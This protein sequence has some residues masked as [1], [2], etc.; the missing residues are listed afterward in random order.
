MSGDEISHKVNRALVWVGAAQT[1]VSLLDMVSVLLILRLWMSVTEYGLAMIAYTL[2]PALDIIGDLGVTSAIVQRDER[3]QERLS[4]LFWFNLLVA[5]G[6]FLILCG[7]GPLLA[8]IHG[9]AV[10]AWMLIVY[11]GKLMFQNLYSIPG[12]LMRRDLR[13]G[14]LSAIRVLANFAEAV[15]KVALAWAGMHLWC[16][17]L[18][19]LCRVLVTAIGIQWCNPW[20]PRLTWRPRE[21]AGAL[22]FGVR[23]SASQILY[24]TYSNLDYQVV[25]YFFGKAQLGLYTAA[26]N[27]VLEPVKIISGIVEQVAFPAFSRLRHD[28]GRLFEQ[29]VQFTRVN[30]A[31]V[32]PYVALMAIICGDFTA[33]VLPRWSAAVPAT[34]VLCIAG[35]VRA[36]SAIGPPLLFGIGKP[37]LV[38][39]YMVTATVALPSLYVLS[40]I[41]LRPLGAVSV[42]IAWAVGY[43]IA[44]WVLAHVTVRELPERAA[45]LLRRVSGTAACTAIAVVP[46]LGVMWLLR[47]ADPLP[48]MSATTATLVSVLVVLLSRWQHMGPRAIAAALSRKKASAA[49]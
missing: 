34:R 20:W 14:E 42:A 25:G 13:F 2:F 48:R 10:V 17:V 21:A 31:T 23:A 7:V 4:T 5:G 11:G 1:A 47:G 41:V 27:L 16:F 36:L 19:A 8:W 45:G 32:L 46:A 9:E 35:L 44:F 24:Y 39:R 22:A 6:V 18:A 28:A 30:L 33:V 49:P 37:Q 38:L 40:A 3:D 26:F 15:A 43:P 29:L 12:A